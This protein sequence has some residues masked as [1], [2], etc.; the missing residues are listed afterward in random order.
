MKH[1]IIVKFNEEVRKEELLEPIKE[2][3]VQALKING[4][5]KVDVHVSNMNLPN[6]HDLMIEMNLTPIGLTEFDNSEIH[7]KW[8]SEYGKY[9]INKTIFDCD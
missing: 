5:N 3:F 7:K 9:I 1:F 4:V 6:R 2:L 8:K